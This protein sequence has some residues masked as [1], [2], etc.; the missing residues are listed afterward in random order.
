MSTETQLERISF[1]SHLSLQMTTC[2]FI[3]RNTD[4]AVRWRTRSF[5]ILKRG[6]PRNLLSQSHPSQDAA[7]HGRVRSFQT[8]KKNCLSTSAFLPRLR[9][10]PSRRSYHVRT[11]LPLPQMQ[12]NP[13][14]AK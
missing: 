3:P 8:R 7:A 6:T 14:C 2:L 10:F 12:S 9:T 11:H 1:M 4:Q 5:Q 13:P